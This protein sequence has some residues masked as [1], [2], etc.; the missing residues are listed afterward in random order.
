MKDKKDQDSPLKTCLK[1][2]GKKAGHGGNIW[3]G[4]EHVALLDKVC[5]TG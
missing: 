5:Y 1:N 4:L 2:N 3:D